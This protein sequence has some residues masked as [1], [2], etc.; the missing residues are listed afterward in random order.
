MF[1]ALIP[2][3][4][5]AAAAPGI[6]TE[7][8]SQNV[9]AGSNAVF[10]VIAN[11]TMPLHYQWQFNG[12]DLAGQ[13]N[14]S[15]TLASVQATDAGS[16]AVVVTN[17]YG[18]VTSAAAL[19]TVVFPPAVLSPPTNRR[20]LE[21]STT[22]FTVTATG[23]APLR[24]QWQKNGT[25]LSDDAR[26]SGST[27]ATISLAMLQ[28]GDAGEYRVIVSNAYGVATSAAA[29]LLVAT[30]LPPLSDSIGVWGD[31]D[32]DG[33]MD[34]LLAGTV[35]GVAGIP[36]GR[37]TRVYHNTG[38]GIFEESGV[39]LPQ[40]DKVS[41]AWGDL[42]NDGDLDL[43]L[44]GLADSTNGPVNVTEIFR[45]DGNY[46]FTKLNAGLEA[47]A[48]GSVA[49]VDFNNDGL[50]DVFVSGLTTASTNWITRLYRNLGN[51]SFTL[52]I[53]NLPAPQ[54]AR[55]Y[56]ADY[57]NDGDVDLLQAGSAATYLLRNEGDGVFTNASLS[58]LGQHRV[59][60]PWGD[61]DGDGDLDFITSSS[62]YPYPGFSRNDGTGAFNSSF[63]YSLDMWL[64]SASWGDIGNDGR[65]SVVV[66]GWVPLVPGG[67]VWG[68]ATR[69]YI[70]LGSTWK[71][72]FT[73]GGWDNR[74]ETWVDIDGD[75]DLDIFTTGGQLTTFWD[76]CVAWHRDFPQAPLNAVATFTALDAVTF[77]WQTPANTPATGRGLSYNVR[78][79]RT[80]GSSDVVSPM[81]D[82]TTGRR[83]IQTS[84]NAGSAHLFKL[85]NVPPGTYYWSVQSIGQSYTGSPFTTEGM[86]TITSSPPVVV[87]QP[88]NVTLLS[89]SNAVF[90]TTVIGTKPL[91]YQWRK[92]GLPLSDNGT[93]S[94]C[95]TLTL[96]I[97]NAQPNL[98][99]AY[100]LVITNNY[101][102]VTSAV[103]ML[104]VQGEPR[105]LSQPANQ[106]ALPT[107]NGGF[108][109]IAAGTAPLSYQWYFNGAP[110]ADSLHWIGSATPSLTISN[111]QSGDTGAYAVIITNAWGSITSSVAVLNLATF[112]YVNVNNPS[113]VS[114]YTSWS[115]AATVIQDAINASGPGDEIQVT[116][117]VYSQG[118]LVG[119]YAAGN[120]V[121]LN[122]PLT[123]VSVNGPA[124]TTIIGYAAPLVSSSGQRCA[125][126]TNGAVLAGF[127]LTQ[128]RV[129][130]TTSWLNHI[131]GGVWCE[132]GGV[133][134]NCFIIGNRAGEGGG[135]IIYGKA[136]NC[137]ISD[138]YSRYNGGGAEHCEV[139]SSTIVG[140]TAS[141][142]GGTYGGSM[143]NSIV[144][145]NQASS[146]ANWY[147]YYGTMTNCCTTPLPGGSGNFT[148]DPAFVDFAAGNYRLQAVSPCINAGENAFVQ[149]AVDLDGHPR[150]T[151]GIV[152]VGAYEH[153]P[154]PWI[155]LSPTNQNAII[156]SNATLSVIALGDAPLTFRWQKNGADLADEGRILGSLGTALTISPVN[157]QDGGSYRVIVTNSLGSVTSSVAILTILGPPIISVQPVSKTAPAGSNTSFR[158]TASGLA[159]LSYQWRLDEADLPGETNSTLQL[160]N[161]Q[162]A[163][164]GN[165]DVVITN[166]YGTLTSTIA[167]L[168]V[169]PAGPSI[170]TQ[171]LSR[172]ASVG[173]NVA[174]TVVAKG[175][176]PMTCQWQREGTNLPG[177]NTFTLVLSNVNSSFNGIYRAAVSNGIGFAFST[178]ATLVVSPVLIWGQT[179]DPQLFVNAAIPATATNVI[180]IAAANGPV[181]GIPCLALRADGSIT[182][183]GNSLRDQVGPPANAVDVVAISL[184]GNAGTVNNLVLRADGMVVNW[185]SSSKLPP[186]TITNGNIVAIAAGGSHQL[187]LH[188]DGTVFA[189]GSNI[190]GQ[191]NVPPNATNVIAIAAGVSHSLALRADGTVVGWGLNTSGEASALSNLA[192]IVSIAAGGNQS[193]ALLAD[194]SVVGR[195]VSNTPTVAVYYGPPMGNASNKISIAAGLYHSL[196]L[197]ADSTLNGWGATNYGQLNMPTFATNVV[198]IAAG[199]NTS[200]ALVRDPFA[201]PIPPRIARPPFGRA[202]M[203][204]DNVVFNALAIG[205]LPLRYQ[206]LRNGAAVAGQTNTWLL[207]TN[208]HPADAGDYQLVAMNDFGSTT[209]L[210]ATVTASIP[211]PVMKWLDHHAD[212]FN[213]SWNGLGGVLY[214]CEYATSLELADWTEFD[215]RLGNDEVETI[216][217]TNTL[218]QT[219][220][221]RI[222]AVYPPPP[223]G[224]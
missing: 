46:Q 137:V 203:A 12:A 216:T 27:N 162:A 110:L 41:A 21:G 22:N 94:G 214:V 91:V 217:D 59:I 128:G 166:V 81:A 90:A 124:V 30:N 206:W 104:V 57:D 102:S 188:D 116:N 38:G 157:A 122:K 6:T 185:T 224:D 133:V 44:S 169:L 77:S 32:N 58:L 135:G 211:Q 48:P 142:G 190:Y 155:L 163:N 19:L 186:T 39:A 200:L 215:R 92:E 196:A 72:V 68:S 174:F 31:C 5:F 97:S 29:T 109:V 222:R 95:T 145:N 7:P 136:V 171:A 83:L 177:A 160:T 61:F 107:R 170:T 130:L 205:S 115:T 2:R 180:A 51:N 210:V 141:S 1:A 78:V 33:L 119:P 187:A 195:I 221:Y 179:N 140:N 149:G 111:V 79:G 218:S 52:A 20:A 65:A 151:G 156:F 89:D 54:N 55:G 173:Q 172:V 40:L 146:G 34:V 197:G 120:R 37:F 207:L 36:D 150:V 14:T 15:L 189:W 184:N 220:F 139:V 10:T 113:P 64:F 164:G 96:T 85:N 4:S 223:A 114:P 213:F 193:L 117:G 26:V 25:D 87:T 183:W 191:T 123:V 56:W 13:T 126:V 219:K 84:G 159:A 67:G 8:H 18:N 105:I 152:D 194:G 182:A 118:G 62:T 165:Y 175:T 100:D 42:D 70:N 103:A 24:Y 16:Y 45:N 125:Y 143:K 28:F 88:T 202:L 53:T 204:G 71:E 199:A 154:A 192:N 153:Q 66:S 212:S 86:F 144:V 132:T 3:A 98:A 158:V 201:L 23:T 35:S 131:G 17:Q 99:G 147:M 198:A 9:L 11:G 50:S 121:S 76:N 101:G 208:A 129:E 161:I 60:S 112:R 49:W 73:L 93:Y 209:S 74:S 178:N 167:T 134:S 69:V 148:N 168:T 47:L 108:A 75:G 176:E 138:N 80:P 127:T 106:Y 181:N 63:D 82:A 43:L